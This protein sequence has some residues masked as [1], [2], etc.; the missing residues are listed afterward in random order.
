[1]YIQKVIYWPKKLW[2]KLNSCWHLVSHGRKKQDPD[3]LVSGTDPRIRIRNKI[4]KI[5]RIHN[6]DTEIL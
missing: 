2:K 5:S 6:T 3:S 4:G 1:M